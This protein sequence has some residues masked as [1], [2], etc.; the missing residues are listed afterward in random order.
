ME[1]CKQALDVCCT[2]LYVC[3]SKIENF[4]PSPSVAG[5]ALLRLRDRIERDPFGALRGWNEYDGENDPCSWFGVECS[6]GKVVAL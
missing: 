1:A 5:L 6:R 2:F 4:L 3:W